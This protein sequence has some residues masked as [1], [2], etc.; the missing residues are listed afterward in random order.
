MALLNFGTTGYQTVQNTVLRVHG[1]S[2]WTGA[3]VESG[4]DRTIELT[5]CGGATL[6]VN[7]VAQGASLAGSV[8]SNRYLV[9]MEAGAGPLN[10]YVPSGQD[11]AVVSTSAGTTV[12]STSFVEVA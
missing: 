11:L 5:N 1:G 9:R 4:T 3:S 12:V 10:V 6:W 7:R 8:S 2:D